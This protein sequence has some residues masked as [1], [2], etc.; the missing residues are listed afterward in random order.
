MWRGLIEAY[1]DRLPV[2]EA[3]PVVTLL[4][5]QHAAAAGAGALRPTRL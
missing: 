2:T 5:G 1:R 3:T 4:R